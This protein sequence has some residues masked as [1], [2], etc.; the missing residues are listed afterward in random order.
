MEEIDFAGLRRLSRGSSVVAG[1][2]FEDL[3]VELGGDG[4]ITRFGCSPSSSSST[5]TTTTAPPPSSSSAATST[6]RV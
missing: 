2:V 1:D 5:T 3:A 4:R 6:T